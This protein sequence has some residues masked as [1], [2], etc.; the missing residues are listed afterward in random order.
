MEIFRAIVVAKFTESGDTKKHMI[1][2][3][4]DMSHLILFYIKLDCP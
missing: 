3:L 2:T 1:T 4:A